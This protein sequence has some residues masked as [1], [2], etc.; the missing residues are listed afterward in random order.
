MLRDN[1]YQLVV[2]DEL[3]YMLAFDYLPEDDVLGALSQRPAA[4]SVVVTGRGGGSALQTLMDTVSEV[5]EVKHAF[6]A[7]IKARQGVDY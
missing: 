3:T 2:L 6:N 4:Q 5:K 1:S 7:G